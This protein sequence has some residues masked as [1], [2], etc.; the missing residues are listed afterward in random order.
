M[1]NSLR[2]F[3]INMADDAS[4]TFGGG[5]RNYLG[6]IGF[7]LP[8]VG[9]EELVRHFVD[10]TH[11]SLP[12]WASTGLIAIGLPIYWS[13]AIWK[14]V[15]GKPESPAQ[16]PLEYLRDENAGLGSAIRDM[17]WSSAWGKW[18]A[19]QQL[20]NS[21][22]PDEA[23][24][25][26]AAD[27]NVRQALVNGHL[28]ARG[29][30]PGQLDYE[31]IPATHWHSTVPHMIPDSRSLWKMILI[32]TGGAEFQP[33]GTIIGHD[34]AATER[35][36]LLQQ[37]DSIIINAREFEK[38]WPRKDAKADSGRRHNLKLAK[39][40]GVDPSELAKLQRD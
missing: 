24:L 19:A 38:L 3:G 2:P 26:R 13:P 20:A 5:L 27:F 37:Y 33:D 35:T 9:V 4:E 1:M 25:M 18:Y 34:T 21:H 30:R 6:A 10:T 32:P 22:R 40:A 16:K 7:I 14:K 31:D 15:H 36:A 29:R 28:K 12:W 11:P 23:G 8:L 39:K 17:A